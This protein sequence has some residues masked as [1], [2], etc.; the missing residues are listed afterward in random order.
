V[1]RSIPQAVDASAEGPARGRE[2]HGR[3]CPGQP[4]ALAAH[5]PRPCRWLKSELPA[6]QKGKLGGAE[7]LPALLWPHT[8][9]ERMTGAGELKA[10][11]I[12]G[13]PKAAPAVK[14]AG[15]QP[16]GLPCRDDIKEIRACWANT[17]LT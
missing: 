5:G 7:P 1:T 10:G 8:L 11:P 2:L 16:A 12:A 15:P 4:G 9:R 13:N 14:P 3:N 17:A 6:I